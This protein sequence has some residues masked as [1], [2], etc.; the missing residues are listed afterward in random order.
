MDANRFFSVSYDIA[1]R[2]KVRRLMKVG[3]GMAELGRWVALLAILYD[4]KGDVVVDDEVKR[5]V[6]EEMLHTDDLE[7]F[8]VMCATCDLIEI[9]YSDGH[10]KIESKS[11]KRELRNKKKIKEQKSKAGKMGAKARAEKMAEDQAEADG[12]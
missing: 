11:V 5:E 8:A 1:S 9:S 7:G 10:L 12:D 2:P 6:L 3:D 4:A